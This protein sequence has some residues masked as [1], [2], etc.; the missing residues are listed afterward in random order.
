[1]ANEF[2]Q[3]ESFSNLVSDLDEIFSKYIRIKHSNKDGIA[4][5]YTSGVELPYTILQCGHFIPRSHLSTRWLEENCRPQAQFDNCYLSGN[6]KIFATNLDIEKKGTTKMLYEMSK[7]IYKP[8]ISELKELI[9][10][11]RGK[12]RIAKLKFKQ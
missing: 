8:T 10:E 1:M 4:K 11:Y 9:I 3:G 12:V 5:C 2:V 7:E 6:L